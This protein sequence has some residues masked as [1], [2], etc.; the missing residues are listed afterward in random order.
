MGTGLYLSMNKVTAVN[1]NDFSNDYS[2][3]RALAKQVLN[4]KQEAFDDFFNQYY[5]RMYRFCA[6]RVPQNDA[7]DIAMNTIAQ[8]LRRMETYRGEASL[9]TWVYQIARSQVSAYFRQE[10]KHQPVV[11]F[12]DNEA[13]RQEVEAL[14]DDTLNSPESEE[15]ANQ[16]Q[17]LI[18]S[19]LDQLPSNYGDL[20]EWK[21]VQG[22][23]VSEMAERLSVNN[24]SVQSSLARARKAFK[25]SYAKVQEHLKDQLQ[26]QLG[27]VVNPSTAT[28]KGA[29]Q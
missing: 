17:Q 8:A 5:T 3:D 29:S 6:K 7:E 26:E 19:I 2:K 25:A 22:L 18:H 11:L 14:A 1:S 24:V 4:G 20:L 12:E 13:L 10:A 21:Y 28:F 15:M 27:E 9:L 23:S 16:R